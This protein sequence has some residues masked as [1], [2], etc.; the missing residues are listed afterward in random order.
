MKFS[1]ANP[2]FE[3]LDVRDRHLSLF[4][5]LLHYAGGMRVNK[6]YQEEC[7]T[8]ILD[9]DVPPDVSQEQSKGE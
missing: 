1:P 2:D 6:T 3:D 4:L 7:Q 5:G 9:E 8:D